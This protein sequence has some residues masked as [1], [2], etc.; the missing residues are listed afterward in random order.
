MSA[1]PDAAIDRHGFEG[2]IAVVVLAMT[3]VVVGDVAIPVATV[4][5]PLVA[6]L[7]IVLPGLL[8]LSVLV[9]VVAHG[10]RVGMAVVDADRRVQPGDTAVSRLL[11]SFVLGTFAVHALSWAIA[12]LYVLIFSTMGGVS[13]AIW[14]LFAGAALA[15]LVLTREAYGTLFSTGPTSGFRRT[16]A[17]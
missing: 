9:G 16:T 7:V 1:L 8:A 6:A 14:A 10:W 5:D 17:E 4:P 2:A 11:A 3:A 13:P 15:G 12:S